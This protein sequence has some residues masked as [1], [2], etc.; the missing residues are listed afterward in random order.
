MKS[1]KPPS[2]VI[3]TQ[4]EDELLEVLIDYLG[5]QIV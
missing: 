1:L 3:G 2:P 5:P 4:V